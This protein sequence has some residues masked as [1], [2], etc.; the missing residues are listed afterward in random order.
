ME[1]VLAIIGSIV[2]PCIF[3][4]FSPESIKKWLRFGRDKKADGSLRFLVRLGQSSSDYWDEVDKPFST[5]HIQPFQ[6]KCSQHFQISIQKFVDD[7][8]PSFD[9]TI[10]SEL[11]SAAVIH[12]I[13]LEIESI[14]HEA[15][16]YG[17]AQAAKIEQQASY[18]VCIPDVW[19]ELKSANERFPRLLEPKKIGRSVSIDTSDIF[20]IEPESTLRYEILLKNY[21]AHMPNYAILRFWVQTQHRRHVSDPI[22]IFTL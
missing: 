14:A 7:V 6:E 5:N 22:H 17:M 12:R 16:G 15:K 3:W 19:A 1:T 18:T 9:I 4:Y 2:L 10:I 20:R 11:N 21:V 13:G 8:D